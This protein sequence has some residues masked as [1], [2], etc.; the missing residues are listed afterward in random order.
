MPNSCCCCRLPPV[1]SWPLGLPRLCTSKE[2]H[3]GIKTHNMLILTF[4]RLA[5][6]KPVDAFYFTGA[7]SHAATTPHLTDPPSVPGVSLSTVGYGDITP[8]TKVGFPARRLQPQLRAHRLLFFPFLTRGV[9]QAP[10][11]WPSL[12]LGSSRR[13]VKLSAR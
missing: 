5:G 12:A 9:R 8:Q 4:N 1:A 6:L 3:N 13:L 11:L 2:L 10:S 7:E